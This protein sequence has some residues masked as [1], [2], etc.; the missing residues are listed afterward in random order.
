MLQASTLSH[1]GEIFMLDMGE[2]VNIL[3]LAERMVRLSGHQV[4]TEIPVAVGLRVE[5]LVRIACQHPLIEVLGR[6]QRGPVAQENIQ[7][8]EPLH[9]AAEHDQTERQRHG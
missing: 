9:V 4:G 5:R 3:E 2:A 1:G 6:R 7:E 8:L